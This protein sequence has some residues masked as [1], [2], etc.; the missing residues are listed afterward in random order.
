VASPLG[1]DRRRLWHVDRAGGGFLLVPILLLLYPNELETI[2][3]VPG[4]N[5]R[6]NLIRQSRSFSRLLKE[7]P[8]TASSESEFLDLHSTRVHA[9]LL[10][11]HELPGAIFDIHAAN[12][13][14]HLF[15]IL[16]F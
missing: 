9:S 7:Y 12:G 4:Q 13:N 15:G 1:F 10:A 14:I 8:S 11:S 3:I 2:T 16:Q 6:M 5:D